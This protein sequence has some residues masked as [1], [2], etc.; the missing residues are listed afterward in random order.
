MG[1]WCTINVFSTTTSKTINESPN[2]YLHS[3]MRR[4]EFPIKT[5]VLQNNKALQVYSIKK[6]NGITRHKQES[7]PVIVSTTETDDPGI[8]TESNSNT[9]IESDLNIP[10][11]SDLDI[12]IAIRKGKRIIHPIE[13]YVSYFHLSPSF[14][15]YTANLSNLKIPKD[16]N[17]AL[18]VHQWKIIVQEE[19]KALYKNETWELGNNPDEILKIKNLLVEEIEIKDLGMLRYFIGIK[20][21][22]NKQGR[23]MEIYMDDMLIKSREAQDHEANLRDSCENLRKY[24]LRLNPDKC[25]FGVTSRKFVGYMI[26]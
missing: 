11:Q 2:S 9:S 23:N 16:I 18:N 12:P 6:N 1:S 21:A 24:N 26:S 25:V 20:M 15:A 22:Q 7:N 14:G 5:E 19:I 17:E 13:R 4:N 10:S 3:D 8:P